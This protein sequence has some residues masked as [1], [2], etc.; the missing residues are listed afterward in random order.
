MKLSV[1]AASFVGASGAALLR[2]A[3]DVWV[4]H[5]YKRERHD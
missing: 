3:L 1:I 5:K 2:T 4:W